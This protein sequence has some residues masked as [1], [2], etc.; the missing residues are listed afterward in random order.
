MP[1]ANLFVDCDD[2]L[3]IYEDSGSEVAE[4]LKGKACFA[5]LDLASSTDIAAFVLAFTEYDPKEVSHQARYNIPPD[6]QE[7]EKYI[8]ILPYFWIPSESMEKRVRTDKVPYDEWVR[9]GFI[10][11]TEGNVISYADIQHDIVE[12]SKTFA[13]TQVAFDRWG[14]I[15]MSQNLTD[16]GFTMVDFGQGYKSMSPPTKDLLKVVLEGKI[17]HG[18]HPV[19]RWMCE[20]LVVGT[21]AA[22]N[23]KPLKDKSIERIDGMVALIMA[24]DGMARREPPSVYTERGIITVS[25]KDEDEWERKAQEQPE[26]PTQPEPEELTQDEVHR[27][28]YKSSED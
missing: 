28:R 16:D 24:I 22:E 21:D 1:T 3:I 6:P 26:K 15:E 18:G 19:L 27:K 4:M 25:G 12:L 9:Q 17:R 23:V 14:A 7:L 5:G 13:I 2:T 8:Y 10:K 11:A 20:N